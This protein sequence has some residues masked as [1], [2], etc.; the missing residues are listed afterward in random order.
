M[1]MYQ[2]MNVVSG[3]LYTEAD[4]SLKTYRNRQLDP[5]SQSDWETDNTSINE[6]SNTQE[7]MQT[8]KRVP[9]VLKIQPQ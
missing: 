1:L 6:T 9:P 4:N 5:E 3:S 2:T 7:V 8:T